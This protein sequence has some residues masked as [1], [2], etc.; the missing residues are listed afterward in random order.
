MLPGCVPFPD[1]YAERYR[2]EGYWRGER[3][4]DLLRRWAAA[5]GD[6]VAV[7]ATGGRGPSEIGRA[8]V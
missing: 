6:R 4:G 2:R 5:G 8:H 7:T 1:E 3:L